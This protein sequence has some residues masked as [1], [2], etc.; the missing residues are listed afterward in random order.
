MARYQT[1]AFRLFIDTRAKVELY[2]PK[3]KTSDS[4][5]VTLAIVAYKLFIIA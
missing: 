5:L 4:W 3:R 1:L 2:K